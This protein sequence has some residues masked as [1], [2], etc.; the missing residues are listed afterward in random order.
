MFRQLQKSLGGA[1]RGGKEDPWH[2]LS[3]SSTVSKTLKE[4]RA[5]KHTENQDYFHA[6]K[7][8]HKQLMEKTHR[9]HLDMQLASVYNHHEE[10]LKGRTETCLQQLTLSLSDHCSARRFGKVE[11]SGKG[12]GEGVECGDME[13]NV[14]DWKEKMNYFDVQLDKNLTFSSSYNQLT[15]S[16]RKDKVP[17]QETTCPAWNTGL[18][19]TTTLDPQHPLRIIY[20]ASKKPLHI[21]KNSLSEC[22]I[23]F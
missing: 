5:S 1:H 17:R 16:S 8:P 6:H 12:W 13:K 15:L 22:T 14:V 20:S 2:R 10:F 7:T 4:K 23:L 18:P 3:L 21:S 9:D 19:P 11:C